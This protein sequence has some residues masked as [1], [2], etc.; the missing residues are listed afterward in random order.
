MRFCISVFLLLLLAMAP[1]RGAERFG[2][3][4]F[5]D[6]VDFEGDLDDDAVT[7]DRLISF[8][9]W[10]RAHDWHPISLDDVDAARRG[11]KPL[12]ERA[13]LITFDDGYRSLYTRVFPL[14]LAYRIP[15]VAALVGSWLDAPMDATVRYGDRD[16]PR[17]RFLSREEMREM[18]HS[19]LVEFA[20][21]SFNLHTGIRGNPQ[22][23]EFA[24]ASSRRFTP[25]RGYESDTAFRRR[26]SEDLMRSRDQLRSLVGRAPR[27]MV[28]PFGRYNGAAVEVIKDLGFEFALT[29]DPEPGN[30]KMPLAI[31][32]YLPNHNPGL[33][34]IVSSLRFD[35]AW[36]AAQRLVALDPGVLWTGDAAGTDGRLGQAIERLRTLGATGVVIEAAVIGP[37]GRLT[38]TW[39]PNGELPVR[40]DLLSRV[41]WQC[42][43]RTG[44]MTYVRLPSSAALRTLGERRKV[45]ALFRDLG[46]HVPMGGMFIDDAP[47]LAQYGPARRKKDMP[48]DVRNARQGVAPDSLPAED[49][50]ALDRFRAVEYSRPGL[51]LVVVID[52]D[53][54]LRPSPIADLVL[55]PIAP[56]PRA[57]ERV[58]KRIQPDGSLTVPTSRRVGLWF[59]GNRPPK[60]RDLISATRRFQREG[61][62]VIGWAGDDPI[63]DLPNAKTVAP[64]VSASR[65]PVKF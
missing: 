5:H 7:V 33:E 44:A 31:G 36:P 45:H 4:A 2:A 48:W 42:Q 17:S 6:V 65:F 40:A 27:T 19:G 26:I 29:L 37:D 18:A 53:S 23:N 1:L 8:F 43:T 15:I 10:L 52:R 60:A 62:T 59:T 22:G 46:V 64:T 24:A 51:Q 35:D 56:E 39:F 16:V 20:S 9:E 11:K 21:H 49:A 57:V 30:V 63:H 13:I 38:A 58:A 41:A 14:V 61:G 54:T 34:S 47:G 50:L 3:I 28:W 32:R 25:G 12:P 55:L